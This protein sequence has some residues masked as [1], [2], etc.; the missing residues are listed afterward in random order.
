MVACYMSKLMVCGLPQ[1]G[2]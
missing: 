2:N 1:V